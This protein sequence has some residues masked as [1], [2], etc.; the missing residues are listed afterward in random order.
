MSGPENNVAKV[1]AE[2]TGRSTQENG[3]KSALTLTLSPSAAASLWRDAGEGIAIGRFR[4]YEIHC[5][6]QSSAHGT[7]RLRSSNTLALSCRS[8]S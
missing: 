2:I 1:E 3:L 5:A 6:T 8:F 7:V 4:F